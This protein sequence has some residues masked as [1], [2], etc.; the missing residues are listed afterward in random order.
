VADFYGIDGTN[1]L[2]IS[3]VFHKAWGQ[4]NEAGTEAAA[5]TVVVA[6]GAQGGGIDDHPHPVFRADHPFIFFI[7]D[8]QSGSLLFMGRLANPSQSPPTPTMPLLA[9][10]RS[11]NGLNISWPYPST[12]WTLQQNPDLSATNWVAGSGISN[13]GTN[14]LM[15]VASPSGNL[16]FRLSHLLSP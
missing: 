11:G 15:T 2:F 6:N 7:R 1:D 4:V 8:T 9:M 5:A 10:T 16:F 3:H 14:Y 12:G 13:D